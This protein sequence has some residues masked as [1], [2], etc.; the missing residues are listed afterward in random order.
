[1]EGRFEARCGELLDQACV[2][3]EDWQEVMTQ[4]D[5]FAK[6]FAQTLVETAQRRHLVEYVSGLLSTLERKTSEGIAYLHGQ[7][8]KQL[9]QFIGES[10]WE[11]TPLINELTRQIGAQIGEPDG[12]IVFDPSAF[13]KK[14]TKSVGVARQW[15]GR[16]GKVDSC[17]VGVYL[18]Y[19]SS[20]EHALSN[21]RLYLPQEWTQDRKRCRAAGVPKTVKFQ[22]RHDQALEMLDESGPLL[23]HS[24][25]AG[26]DE[27]GRCGPFREALRT[28]GERYLLAV[29]S[30]TLVRDGEVS[31]P[32]YSGRGRH[33]QVPWQRVDAWRASQPETAWTTL[34][35]RDGEQ[36]PLVTE[37]IKRRVQARTPT[38]GTGP[39]EVLFITREQQSDGTYKHDYYLS[40]A[41][42]ATPLKEF[43]RVAKAEHRIEECFQRAK[44]EAG[45]G[46]YQVRNWIGW[47]HH[48]TLSL[49]AAWF[50]NDQTRRGKNPDP[51]ADRSPHPPTD[52]RPDRTPPPI[53]HPDP[54]RRDRPTLAPTQ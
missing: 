5:A 3:P 11:H 26:D 52:R 14:G 15:S 33:P 54:R 28:R 53:P 32:K 40:N 38:G 43:A 17:Q 23:P 2:R 49:I 41:D 18:G 29:P 6:P 22:T 10:P 46:D 35:V 44:S 1:M 36:G 24:W 31:P 39:E 47:Q 7:D 4:L 12:V 42:A 34:D 50:L 30:N 13:A 21:T 19:V 16:L 8:R 9:Q 51:R 27:M 45:L 48:Q 25:I 37:V 20:R